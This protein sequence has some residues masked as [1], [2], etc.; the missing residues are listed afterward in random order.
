MNPYQRVIEVLAHTIQDLVHYNGV[1]VSNSSGDIHSN[2]LLHHKLL[3]HH[4][5]H[6]HSSGGG[7]VYTPAAATRVQ[8]PAFGFGDVVTKDHSVFPLRKDGQPCA[9]FHDVLA[10]YR[11]TVASVQLSGPTSFEPIIR[12]SIDIVQQTGRYHLLVV[13]A[14]G[15]FVDER[16][17]AQAI[18]DASEHPLSI[19][20]VGVGDGPWEIL[21]RFDDWLPERRF[22]NFQ[23]VEYSQVIK[24]CGG[25]GKHFDTALAL[26]IFMEVPDQY[27]VV[28]KLGYLS[29][30]RE[31]AASATTA[32]AAVTTVAEHAAAKVAAAGM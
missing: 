20:V 22:D 29:A 18:V 31:K 5:H 9:D 8:I 21:Q 17:T 25:S 27:K 12:K 16:P 3:H 13:I 19:V 10:N 24:Q 23:F 4:H 2:K 26:N 30:A 32:A 1:Q 15:Q 14:D 7:G 11:S 6:H 28:N